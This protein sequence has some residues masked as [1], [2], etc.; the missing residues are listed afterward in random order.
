MIDPGDPGS[1]ARAAYGI[2]GIHRAHGAAAQVAKRRAAEQAVFAGFAKGHRA[3]AQRLFAADALEE[4][5]EHGRSTTA[6]GVPPSRALNFY[7]RIST[8]D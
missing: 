4:K 3:A 6:K 1:G 7:T 2:F 5:I 8:V